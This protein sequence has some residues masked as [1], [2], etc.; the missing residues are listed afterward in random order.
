MQRPGNELYLMETYGHFELLMSAWYKGFE[1]PI[2]WV[3]PYGHGRVCYTALGHADVQ[4]KNPNFQR[5]IINAIRWSAAVD[6]G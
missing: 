1:R 2:T 4:H 5:L 6:E 3:K